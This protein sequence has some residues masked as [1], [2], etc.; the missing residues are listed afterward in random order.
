MA[1]MRKTADGNGFL[2]CP[3]GVLVRFSDG[4]G[5]CVSCGL[6]AAQIIA[7][8]KRTCVLLTCGKEFIPEHS[9]QK[10]CCANHGRQYELQEQTRRNRERRAAE[11]AE[12]Q[13][14]SEQEYLDM[15]AADRAKREQK[16]HYERVRRAAKA[17]VQCSDPFA[18]EVAQGVP[19]AHSWAGLDPLPCGGIP[20]RF[21][22]T[23]AQA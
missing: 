4:Q 11:L 22:P 10:T 14:R 1:R 15:L 5:E 3:C 12:R 7:A 19:W 9:C 20:E 17:M 8:R 23:A 6:S 13:K 2:R 21:K 18:G 16:S